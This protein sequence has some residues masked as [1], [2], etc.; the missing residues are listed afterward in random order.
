MITPSRH[1]FNT[2]YVE[3][4]IYIY[5]Y[6]PIPDLVLVSKIDSATLNKTKDRFTIN[7]IA[8]IGQQL[9]IIEDRCEILTYLKIKFPEGK[10]Q[11]SK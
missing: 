9:Y 8:T 10:I 5:K 1:L 11:E 2:W 6:T 3:N 7:E 4:V